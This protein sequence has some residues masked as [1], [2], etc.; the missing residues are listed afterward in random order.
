MA[1]SMASAVP[2]ALPVRAEIG[3]RQSASCRQ[4]AGLAPSAP[5][6]LGLSQRKGSWLGSC[7]EAALFS[8]T[9]PSRGQG[10]VHWRTAASSSAA[11]PA[12]D[13]PPPVGAGAPLRV[14]ITGGTKGVGYC[15]AREFLGLGDRV[16]ICGR[17]GA[18]IESA[19]AA[20]RKDF[21]GA[22]ITG[23]QCDVS[24]PDSISKFAESAAGA[25][26][27]VD[28]WINN[29][30]QVTRKKLLSDLDSDE[31]V[32]VVGVNVIGSMLGC[33]EAIKIFRGQERREGSVGPC[34][35]VFNLGFSSWGA[36]FSKSACTHKS[37]KSAL[38][39]L[40]QFLGAELEEA[41][42]DT[43]GVH[44]LSPGMVLTDLLLLDSTPVARRFF[45]ALAEE[46]ETV[47][48][49]LVPRVRAVQGTRTSIEF[50][51]PAGTLLRVLTG[52][53]Q[54]LGGGRFFDKDGERV[55]EPGSTYQNNGVKVLFDGADKGRG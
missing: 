48:A 52:V 17:D 54:I 1:A 4:G 39:Q 23:I 13:A 10:L 11:Q 44:N 31:I 43:V 14:V 32:R 3:F 9:I 18:R 21:P 27:G 40:T 2:L 51:D 7:G 19:L 28:I 49:D 24:Q 15:M 26:G 41:G 37:T 55:R 50:L 8:T 20:L 33:K 12:P 42:V 34:Y 29:A 25:L 38:T 36:G 47:A 30:G 35:H 16:V 45:N 5:A 46:A 53:P 22:V 6:G